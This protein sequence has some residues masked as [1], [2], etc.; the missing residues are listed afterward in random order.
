MRQID[1]TGL[2]LIKSFEHF[3]SYPYKDSVGVW[4]IGYGHTR[5]VDMYSTPVTES[6]AEDMLCVDLAEAQKAVCNLIH[7]ALTDNQYSALVSLVYNAGPAPLQRTLGG[8]LNA[9]DYAA[10]AD[11]FLI[12][13]HAGGTIIAGL[14]RRRTIERTLFLL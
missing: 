11:Q 1:Q 12:W 10:A 6:Q 7:V 5:G 14:T 4:T 2:E 9:G 8:L 13:N 3:R